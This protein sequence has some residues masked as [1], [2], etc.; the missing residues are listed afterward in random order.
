MRLSHQIERYLTT[1]GQT[2]VSDLS[3]HFGIS[4]SRCVEELAGLIPYGVQLREDGAVLA[5]L[6]PVTVGGDSRF[7]DYSNF[8]NDWLD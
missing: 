3:R 5:C 1:E 4:E 8:G 2:T 7:S 6:E